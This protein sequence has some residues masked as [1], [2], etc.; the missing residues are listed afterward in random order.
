MA[1]Q[2][3]IDVP[4][5]DGRATLAGDEQV[6]PVGFEGDTANA[7]VPVK[8]L[9]ALTV[10]IEVPDEPGLIAEG[11]TALTRMKKSAKV[12]VAEVE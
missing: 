5:E 4:G 8:P 1:L 9:R 7:T 2:E 3:S 10:I 6:N 12:K 11:V